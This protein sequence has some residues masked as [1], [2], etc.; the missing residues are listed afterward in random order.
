VKAYGQ[1]KLQMTSPPNGI[2]TPTQVE[3]ETTSTKC[4]EAQEQERR[5]Y[6][7]SI[8]AGVDSSRVLAQSD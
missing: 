2:S 3:I 5:L 6:R 7:E 1:G 8:E 4:Q